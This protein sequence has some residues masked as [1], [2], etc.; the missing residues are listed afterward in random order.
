MSEPTSQVI[1]V[2][3]SSPRARLRRWRLAAAAAALMLG[4]GA[5]PGSAQTLTEALSY[6]YNSN[7]QLL[8]QRAL[9]RQTDEGVPQALSNW[10]PTVTF[11]GEAG[12]NRGAINEGTGDQFST[13]LTR[14]LDL[15]VTQPVYRGGRT[16]AQTRQA[17][18]LVQ[19]ARAATLGVET[20]V[21][22]AVAQ[23]F[24][25]TYRDQ[26]LVEVNRNNEAVLKKQLDATR[27]RFRVGEVTR[28]DVA[29]AE[30]SLAQA[31]ANRIASEGQL[32]V[33]RAAYTRAVGHPPGRLV[34]TNERPIL[35]QGRDDVLALAA[36]DNFNVMSAN[37]A[38]AAARDN[39]D[40]V[41]G[42]LLPQISII[43][44]LNRSY[45][46]SITLKTA[47]EDTASVVAQMTMPLYEGG[48]VYSQ[49]RQAEQTVG[50]RRSQVDDA[51]RA[52][53]QSATQAWET[54][55]SARA[56][57]A[58]FG[59][60]VKAAQIALEGT[61]QEALVGSRTVLDVLIS[62]QQ[63]FTTQ[64]QLVGAQHDASVA[65]YNVAAA[66]GRLIAPEL[67]L[68]VQLYDMDKHYRRVKG[69][70]VGFSGGLKE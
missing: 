37:F 29:Q 64:S 6:A 16:E 5:A 13:F 31:T 68:P 32:E 70:W 44:D 46:P 15:R 25:D 69:K 53:V 62:E 60:A 40:V 49:T 59:A 21:F 24:F 7:P 38:E 39:I 54:L 57:V 4:A 26:T 34:L 18:N 52:A 66:I 8:A 65:E 2:P 28:T 56:A 3:A 11:T 67:N 41:R 14:E 30:S 9:L 51:R 36:S 17:V 33:S 58:S 23:A 45:S 22:Q 19:A 27:D 43:G 42:Q 55:M 12:I 48:A 10:R 35:P 50:Q 20:T 61:Q 1:P 47:R 63:L